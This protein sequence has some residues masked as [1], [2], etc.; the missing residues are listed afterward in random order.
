MGENDAKPGGL[1]PGRDGMRAV[2]ASLRLSLPNRVSL[3]ALPPADAKDARGWLT[4]PARAALSWP[5][6]GAMLAV[7]LVPDEPERPPPPSAAGDARA[8]P[9]PID[10]AAFLGPLGE[11]VRLAAPH[12]EAD[13]AAVLLQVLVLFGNAIGR[14]AFVEVGPD[15]HHGNEFLVVVGETSGGRKGTSLGVAKAVFEGVDDEWLGGRVLSGLSSGEGLIHAVR[16]PVEGQQPCKEKGRTVD[17]EKIVTDPGVADKRL[18]ADEP[19]FVGVLKQAERS[20]N[21]L[22]AVARQAWES[23]HLRTLTNQGDRRARFADRAHHQSGTQEVPRR[24]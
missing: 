7:A 5:E 21:I 6:R 24:G 9:E 3:A 1:W 12:T 19:E 16:D 13:P 10:D 2:A 11:Y 14:G 20:E 15:R 4:D 22:S 23:G 17:Y 8:W 18:V